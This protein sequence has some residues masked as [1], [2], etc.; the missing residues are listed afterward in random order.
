MPDTARSLEARVDSAISHSPH[1]TGLAVQIETHAGRVILHGVVS[2]YYQ[3]Q[4]A[5]EAIRRVEGVDEIDNRLE[6]CWPQG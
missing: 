2:S 5:Q 6:V 4:V 3:K 1:L